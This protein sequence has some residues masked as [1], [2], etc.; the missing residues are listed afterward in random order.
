MSLLLEG[1][2]ASK[3]CEGDSLIVD[4]PPD[5][6]SVH[7]AGDEDGFEVIEIFKVSGVDEGEDDE[8]EHEDED[9]TSA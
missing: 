5:K 8:E 9:C 4:H 6:D 7:G 1:F 2:G 3:R